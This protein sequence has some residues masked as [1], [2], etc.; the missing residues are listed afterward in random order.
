MGGTAVECVMCRGGTLKP[1]FSLVALD[2]GESVII[3]KGVP[4]LVC[5]QCGEFCLEE[6][7]TTRV[8]AMAE[9]AFKRGVEV[10]IVKWKT[11]TTDLTSV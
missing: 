2:R 1:G 4:S 9:D 11:P 5:N 8:Q 6:D 10:E 3:I 7:T